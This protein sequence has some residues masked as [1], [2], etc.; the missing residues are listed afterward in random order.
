M[1]QMAV[2]EEDMKVELLRCVMPA[3]V[4]DAVPFTR[5][6]ATVAAVE[7]KAKERPQLD[8]LS[9]NVVLY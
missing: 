6:F 2:G 4:A 5:T 9:Q 7:A 3:G 8:L 1:I